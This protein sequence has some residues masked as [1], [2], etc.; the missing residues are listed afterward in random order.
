MSIPN[1]SKG[2]NTPKKRIIEFQ[3]KHLYVKNNELWCRPCN[4]KID[5]DKKSSVKQHLETKTHLNLINLVKS[6]KKPNFQKED[7]NEIKKQFSKDLMTGFASANIPVH[8]LENKVLKNILSKYLKDEVADAWP[9]STTVRKTLPDIH[10]LES[11]YLKD[12]LKGKK[13]AV[14][15]DE[16]T[17]CEQRYVLNIL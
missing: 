5:F 15:A 16:T 10:D 7:R 3:D 9:S 12:S 17:D 14:F 4:V 13:I 1:K 11:N 2:K 8:K 6:N